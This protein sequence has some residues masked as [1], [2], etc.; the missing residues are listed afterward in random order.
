MTKDMI[1][2][3]YNFNKKG[4]PDELI[5]GN[6]NYQPIPSGDY[7]FLSDDYDDGNNIPG[8]PVDDDLPDNKILEDAVMPN[9]V[10]INNEIIIDDDYSLASD[11]EPLQN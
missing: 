6:F 1:E 9:H 8:A 2:Q 5:F 3:Y 10:D 4:C 11:I 7:N